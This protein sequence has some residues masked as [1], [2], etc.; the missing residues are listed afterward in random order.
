MTATIATIIYT[1]INFINKIRLLLSSI[2]WFFY[3]HYFAYLLY[4]VRTQTINRQSCRWNLIATKRHMNRTC[5]SLSYPDKQS[6]SEIVCIRSRTT[7]VTWLLC[8]MV[9]YVSFVC[10][11]L[12]SFHSTRISYWAMCCTMLESH[13]NVIASIQLYTQWNAFEKFPRSGQA[14]KR[15]RHINR[16]E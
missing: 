10:P 16:N 8:C 15:A 9:V 14:R 4:W 1:A 11:L 6:S 12:H 2:W 3:F 7:T 13:A 5:S